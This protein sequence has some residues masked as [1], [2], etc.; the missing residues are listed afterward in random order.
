MSKVTKILVEV[1]SDSQM[2]KVIEFFRSKAGHGLIVL[3]S[4]LVL[5][6]LTAFLFA[7]TLESIR[8]WKI[9][10]IILGVLFALVFE[11]STFF[12]AVNGYSLASWTAALFSV[13]IA[14]ATFAQMF[15]SAELTN[16]Y[17][18][19]WIMS[20]FPPVIIAYTSHK[21]AKKYNLESLVNSG[22]EVN[23]AEVR[24]LR[25]KNGISVS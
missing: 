5:V 12:L 4:C 1:E 8:G 14:R 23:S 22:N 3:L 11:L 25:S 19:S 15:P 17:L 20:I 2:D 24:P 6:S 21:L 13:V 9:A 7:D 16:L 10:G 18:A